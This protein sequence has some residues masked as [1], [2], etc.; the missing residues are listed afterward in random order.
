MLS[1]TGAITSCAA[2]KTSANS[3]VNRGAES[4]KSKSYFSGISAIKEINESV[5]V[6]GLRSKRSLQLM[7]FS[8]VRSW[9]SLKVSAPD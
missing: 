8:R 9:P 7:T 3:G 2:F 5:A 4:I 1:R 6:C